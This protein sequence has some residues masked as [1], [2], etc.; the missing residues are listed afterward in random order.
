MFPT[1][2]ISLHKQDVSQNDITPGFFDKN[3]QF[4][5][6]WYTRYDIYMT[7]STVRCIVHYLGSFQVLCYHYR[8]DNLV[9]ERQI[10]MR[11]NM[12]QVVWSFIPPT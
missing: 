12:N 10:D 8:I 6:K 11:S 7:M 5:D 1:P 4:G 2:S 9:Q 3:W